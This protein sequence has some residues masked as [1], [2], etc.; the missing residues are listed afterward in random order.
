MFTKV[1]VQDSYKIS[2]KILIRNVQK[3]FLWV[4]YLSE[5]LGHTL[6]FWDRFLW[7]KNENQIL[8]VEG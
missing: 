2:F 3:G 8:S 7:R 1:E 5:K 4:T 6:Q